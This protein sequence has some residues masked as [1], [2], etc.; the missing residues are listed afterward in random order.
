M[1]SDVYDDE[2]GEEDAETLPARKPTRREK[3]GVLAPAIIALVGMIVM[4][5]IVLALAA[6]RN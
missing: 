4:V 5:I 2:R 1:N 3:A 6:S